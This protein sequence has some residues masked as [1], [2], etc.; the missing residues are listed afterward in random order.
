MEY[1]VKMSFF[2]WL[3]DNDTN[4]ADRPK[5]YKAIIPESDIVEWSLLWSSFEISNDAYSDCY[6]YSQEFKTSDDGQWFDVKLFSEDDFRKSEL[7]SQLCPYYAKLFRLDYLDRNKVIK[8][9]TEKLED[10]NKNFR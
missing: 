4:K 9:T 2:D 10:I 8:D 6:S 1:G 3:K 7:S 5:P